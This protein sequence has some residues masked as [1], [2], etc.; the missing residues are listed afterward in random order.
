MIDRKSYAAAFFFLDLSGC[1]IAV[2]AYEDRLALFSISMSADSDIID[3]VSPLSQFSNY[4]EN[5]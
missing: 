2:S 3:K 1:F 5:L 4:V